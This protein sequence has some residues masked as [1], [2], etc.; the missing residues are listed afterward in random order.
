MPIPLA[1]AV[2]EPPTGKL[3]SALSDIAGHGRLAVWH[4]LLGDARELLGFGADV[5]VVDLTLPDR[6][7][8]GIGLPDREVLGALRML[9]ATQ[10]SLRLVL[11]G[12]ESQEVPL[13]D[14]ARSLGASV[15][16]TPATPTEIAGLL[17]RLSGAVGRTDPA[18]FRALAHGL[19]DA[20]HNPL[21]AVSGHLQLLVQGFH[22]QRDRDRR[23]QVDAAIEGAQRIAT[24]LDRLRLLSRTSGD[25]TRS[26]ESVDPVGA[27][28][29]LHS[30][31][32]AAI[33]M[34][35]PPGW[36]SGSFH[37]DPEA[38]S[39]ALAET[40]ELGMALRD[41]GHPVRLEVAR[42]PQGQRIRMLVPP[43]EEAGQGLQ[44]WQ[45]PR[46]Y[47][48]YFINRVLKGTPHGLA[49]FLVQSVVHSH[50][51]RATARRTHD[52]GILL[53]LLWPD[54]MTPDADPAGAT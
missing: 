31:Y 42:T 51:G 21:L 50:G 29:N 2:V 27:L 1:I 26:G 25:P 14:L 46:T 13:H 32:G 8:G 19:A 43:G 39:T 12:P 54:S 48:P 33:P 30:Q 38:V 15:L 3:S 28:R 18:V 7:S 36:V 40:M 44:Q 16:I 23:A 53:D 45:L 41:V 47:E 49:L 37:G 34:D 35:V 20:I 4:D 5:L 17:D 22:P 10:R 6:P 11:A 52:G 24:A 9:Q